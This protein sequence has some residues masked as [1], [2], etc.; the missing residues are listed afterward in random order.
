LLKKI[1]EMV[2]SGD[3]KVIKIRDRATHILPDMVG[4]TLAVHNGKQFV[5]VYITEDML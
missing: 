5:S 3:K 2:A 4:L 1:Q